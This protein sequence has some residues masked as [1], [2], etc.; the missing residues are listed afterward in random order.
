M[1]P[2]ALTNGQLPADFRNL[3]EQ[4]PRNFSIG[5]RS[6]VHSVPWAVRYFPN[7]LLWRQDEFNEPTPVEPGNNDEENLLNPERTLL[8]ARTRAASLGTNRLGSRPGTVVPWGREM[9][10]LALPI[11]W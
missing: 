3:L 7:R 5:R 9:P 10:T 4:G 1:N 11:A 6:G 2:C 8:A